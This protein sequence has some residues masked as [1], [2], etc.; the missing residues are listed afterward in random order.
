MLTVTWIFLLLTPSTIEKAGGPQEARKGHSWRANPKD[1]PYHMKSQSAMKVKRK[2]RKKG[3][4]ELWCLLSLVTVMCGGALLS[5][6]DLNNCLPMGSGELTPC[7]PLLVY[8]TFTFPT[9]MSIS[10]LYHSCCLP[11]L[12]CV[13]SE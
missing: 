5:W 7:F 1:I 13:G 4:S 8:M 9:K 3:H 11:Q 12:H 6:G 10:H 2:R